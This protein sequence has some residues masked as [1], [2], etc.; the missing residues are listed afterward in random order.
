MLTGMDHHVI[1]APLLECATDHAGLDELGPR[2]HDADDDAGWL[3][4]ADV[5][6]GTFSAIHTSEVASAN[7]VGSWINRLSENLISISSGPLR[8]S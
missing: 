7:A 1:R 5:P 3:H 6:V 2:S 8:W 4:L